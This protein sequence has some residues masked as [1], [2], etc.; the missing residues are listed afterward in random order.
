MA[1]SFERTESY[2]L[3]FLEVWKLKVRYMSSC[4]ILSWRVEENELT[5]D[6]THENST[7]R[8]NH[9]LKD[10]TLYTAIMAIEL[11]CGRETEVFQ[12]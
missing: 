1:G 8:L 5:P 10:S 11:G 3:T 6:A 4:Y 12:V 2:L 9:F 7:L